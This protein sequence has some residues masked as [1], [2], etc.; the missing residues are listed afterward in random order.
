AMERVELL[1]PVEPLAAWR[2][3]WWAL[4]PTATGTATPLGA[5]DFAAAAGQAA[6]RMLERIDERGRRPTVLVR[7]AAGP[8]LVSAGDRASLIVVG[9]RGRG[10]V[11][12][13]VLGSVSA[14]CAHHATVPVVIVPSDATVD[15]RFGRVVVGIDGSENGRAALDWAM[16]HT[17]PSSSIDVVH[18]WSSIAP[19]PE[20]AIAAADA[21]REE[22]E[23]FV[24]EAIGT[25]SPEA[26]RTGR[27]VYG[28]THHGDP[29]S[30]L[31]R[32]GEDADLLVVGARGVGLLEYLML[33]SVAASLV[34]QPLTPTVIVR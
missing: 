31:R 21:A 18:A 17:P 34:H 1:G 14:H 20:L 2:Y 4:V 33:G 23:R 27:K 3:P 30:I 19:T 11:A 25:I 5:D 28:Q 9:S 29:R 6:A 24:D 16:A 8:A 12:G 15:D 13:G 10:A 7:G 22:S 26:E 32:A